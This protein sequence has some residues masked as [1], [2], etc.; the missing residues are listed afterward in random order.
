VRIE[1]GTG[2]QVLSTNGSGALVW[3][4]VSPGPSLGNWEFIDNTMYNMAGGEIN[5]GDTTHGATAGLVLPENGNAGLVTSLF[6]TY[7]NIEIAVANLA[8]SA[9]TSV[10]NFGVDGNLTLPAN[11]FAVNYANGTPVTIPTVGN[12]ATLNL[13]GNVSNVLRGDGTFGA[14][15][16]SSYGDSN[17]VTL[18]SAFGSNTITTTGNVSVGNI[19]A[20]NLGNIVS[21]NLDGNVSNL[22]TGNGTYVAIPVVQTVG[23]IATLN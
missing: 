1:G 23:N 19:T 17:V 5:N 8:N 10:W 12:I 15:A 16:N 22:L 21:A 4:N 11:T 3:S 14:D 2:G 13:D 7:G 20:T 6:N 18:L 9:N